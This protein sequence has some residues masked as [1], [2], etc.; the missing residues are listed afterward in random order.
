MIV[1][2]EEIGRLFCVPSATYLEENFPE[3]MEVTVDNL[4]KIYRAGLD[5]DWALSVI[6][7]LKYTRY[8]PDGSRASF[9]ADEFLFLD[10]YDFGP[11]SME[12]REQNWEHYEPALRMT[13]E[14]ALPEAIRKWELGWEFG[15]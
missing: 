10:I 5:A 8:F 6:V 14:R 9:H 13:F 11:K 1:T 3:G 2:A 12:N 15:K 4:L 7:G